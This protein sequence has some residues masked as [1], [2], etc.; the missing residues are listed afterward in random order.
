MKKTAKIKLSE[1]LGL[2]GT[3]SIWLM[4]IG[5][6]PEKMQKCSEI[7]KRLAKGPEMFF[8]HYRTDGINLTNEEWEQYSQGIPAYFL[9]NGRHEPLT[10]E[11]MTKRKTKIY[12]GY[13]TAGSL[14]M[15]KITPE[16]LSKIFHYYLETVCFYPTIDWMTFVESYRNY[17]GHGT[18]DYISQGF[19]DFLFAYV[20]SGD[21]SISFDPNQR[22]KNM[23]SKVVQE[24]L[25]ERANII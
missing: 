11:V 18:R 20:D 25:E 19:T 5:L 9:K 17:M 12:S 3:C 23:I 15:D 16:M 10:T 7:I 6:Y 2:D 1:Y 13:L 4:N 22:D 24:V 8:G 21:F 14:P